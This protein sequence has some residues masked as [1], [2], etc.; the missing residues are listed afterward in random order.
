MAGHLRRGAAGWRC[1]CRSFD[2]FAGGQPGV[3]GEEQRRVALR[4]TCCLAALA[5]WLSLARW[6]KM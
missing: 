3:V 1:L 4:C 2:W 5:G 6:F